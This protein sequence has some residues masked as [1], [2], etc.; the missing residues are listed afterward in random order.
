MPGRAHL[1]KI[2][3]AQLQACVGMLGHGRLPIATAIP[4][5]E[6]TEM[7]EKLSGATSLDA[8]L[9]AEM[10]LACE[11]AGRLAKAGRDGP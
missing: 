7:L 3:L 2:D 10:A 6:A 11:T 4:R 5:G 9:P 8:S 1:K